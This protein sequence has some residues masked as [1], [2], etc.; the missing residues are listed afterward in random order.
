MNSSRFVGRTEAVQRL[1]AV[2][3]GSQKADGTLTIQSVEGP[4][5]IGKTYLLE[6]VI[7]T[8]AL[9]HRN[10]VPF[11]I[12]GNGLEPR[13]LDC[14]VQR[15]LDSVN[16]RAQLKRAVG[17]KFTDTRRV[18]EAV[19]RV[20]SK[21]IEEFQTKHPGDMASREAFGQFLDLAFAL[22]KLV[23]DVVPKTK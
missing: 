4:G 1:S 22:G 6:R 19:Q 3:D 2:L 23:N 13:T 7:G 12:E 18:L 21:A 17:Y 11:G 14:A 8:T 9:G 20:R 16:H 5:G 10:Y 15:L